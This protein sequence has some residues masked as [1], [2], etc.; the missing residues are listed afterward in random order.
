MKQMETEYESLCKKPEQKLQKDMTTL[1][2][3]ISQI[4]RNV[5]NKLKIIHN[6]HSKGEQFNTL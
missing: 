6:D 4:E 2:K 1:N 3:K 5:I